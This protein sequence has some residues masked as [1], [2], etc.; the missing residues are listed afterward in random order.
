MSPG[1]S[2]RLRGVLVRKERSEVAGAEGVS[3]AGLVVM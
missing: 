3:A 1:T 2:R